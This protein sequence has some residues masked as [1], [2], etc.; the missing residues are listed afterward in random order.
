MSRTTRASDTRVRHARPLS[1]CGWRYCP[2]KWDVGRKPR[3]ISNGLLSPLMAALPQKL[4]YRADDTA[5]TLYVELPACRI[6]NRR[7]W[8]LIPVRSDVSS[9]KSAF[10]SHS[11][12]THPTEMKKLARQQTPGC[13]FLVLY[14]QWCGFSNVPYNILVW[15]GVG[16]KAT[17]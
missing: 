9:I 6:H 1:M 4:C 11:T 14:E 16:A 5:L 13:M 17:A 2:C 15:Q 7:E 3:E 8:F 12:V 10:W